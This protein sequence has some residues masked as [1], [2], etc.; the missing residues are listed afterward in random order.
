MFAVTLTPLSYA[1][2]SSTNS[3]LTI[4]FLLGNWCAQ[5]GDTLKLGKNDRCGDAWNSRDATL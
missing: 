5:K 3:L 1:K 4:T 2:L